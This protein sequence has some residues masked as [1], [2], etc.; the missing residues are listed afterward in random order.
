M[1]FV[2]GLGEAGFE[3]PSQPAIAAAIDNAATAIRRDVSM[4]RG[5]AQRGATSSRPT[6]RLFDQPDRLARPSTVLVWFAPR[7]VTVRIVPSRNVAITVTVL[8]EPRPKCRVG[9]S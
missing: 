2:G 4:T 9:S 3:W 1:L 5:I 8:T 7:P 6:H